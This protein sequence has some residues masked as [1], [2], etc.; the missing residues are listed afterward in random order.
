MKEPLNAGYNNYKNIFCSCR[1]AQT[2]RKIFF[3]T[4]VRLR[5]LE[6]HFLHL[7]YGYDSKLV[8]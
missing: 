3:V 8:S 6:N 2:V 7:S 1:T 4:V 5:R